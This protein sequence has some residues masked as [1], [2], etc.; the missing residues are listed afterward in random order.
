MMG[1][2]SRLAV[3]VAGTVALGGCETLMG[4]GRDAGPQPLERLP[5]QLSAQEQAVIR[6]SNSFAFD[7]FRETVRD[8]PSAN[9]LLSP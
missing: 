7:I 8:Q 4:P 2:V 6:A 3:L 1:R 5:R 9:V